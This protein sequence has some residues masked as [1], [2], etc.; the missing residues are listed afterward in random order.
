MQDNNL[1]SALDAV[2]PAELSYQEW[3]SVGMALHTEGQDCCVWESWSRNDERYHPG[4]CE[5]KWLGFECRKSRVLYVNLEIDPASCINRFLKIYEALGIETKHTDDLEIWNLRG[6]ALPLDE[7]VPKLVRRIKSSHFDAVVIDPIY[8]VITGDE[9]SATDMGQFCNQFDA[10]CDK[11]GCSVIYCHHHSKGAQ[12]AK[13]AQDRA[14][15]SGV[16]ARDPDAQLDIIELELTDDIKNFVRDGNATAWRLES[17]L[18]EFE[19]FR[20]VDFWF[21]YPIHRIDEENLKDVY[22]A[23]NRYTSLSKSGKRTSAAERKR[24]LDTAFDINNHDG[25]TKVSDMAL[26]LDLEEKTIRNYLAE[27]KSEYNLERGI[28]TRI[29]TKQ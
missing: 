15:G 14:S 20:P 18:R 26:Y 19:N 22:P 29:K 28:V 8:K 2:N 16:F 10:I 21:D 25:F 9:N 13:K 12:G 1:I 27:H 17:S 4:E 6:K 23:G 7:L 24:R 5:Q 3:L 11:T